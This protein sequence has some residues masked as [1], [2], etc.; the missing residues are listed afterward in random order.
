MNLRMPTRRET[1]AFVRA[2][3]Q[4]YDRNDILTYASATARQLLIAVVP[5]FLLAF[6]LVG[7]FG[8][9]DV[10][11]RELGPKFAKQASA[12]TYRAVDAVVEGLDSTTHATWLV[13][14][15]AILVWEIS[16]A[17]RACMGGLNRIY[18]LEETRS[19]VRR[20]AVSFAIAAPVGTLVL[21]AMLVATRGG[22]W[23][24]LG[25]AQP[26]WTLARWLLVVG[27]LWSVVAVLIRFAPD[28][29]QAK[30]WVTLG[31]ALVIVA[32][33]A[34]SLLFAWWV[35]GVANY[36]TPFG[37][38]IA[39][40]T[41]VGYLYTSSIVFLTGAQIDQLARERVKS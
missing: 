38:M 9:Q 27:L 40:L 23:L 34:V 32:W 20:F 7:A 2:L 13:A 21:G 41:L 10:W 15:V 17:V 37:T 24:D 3:A 31:S 11:R 18:E 26:L 6:L 8:Q 25:I 19:T 1:A 14:A 5:L 33:I 29:Y 39:I 4:R 16:G 36:K 30:G 12:P 22:G 28:G 35:F